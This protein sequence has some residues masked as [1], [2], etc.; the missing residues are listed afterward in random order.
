MKSDTVKYFYTMEGFSKGIRQI[1]GNIKKKVTAEQNLGYLK[2]KDSAVT[3]TANFQQLAAKTQWGKTA[4]QHQFYIGLKDGVK[5]KIIRSKKPDNLQ[6]L[7]AL[8][9]KIDN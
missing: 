6:E 3:Y 4:L 2:Q 5:D 7:I 8:A 9:V 1:F